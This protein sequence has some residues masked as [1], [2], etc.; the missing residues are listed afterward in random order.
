[1]FEFKNIAEAKLKYYHL[2][3]QGPASTLRC[4]V[5]G[6]CSRDGL[7]SLLLIL[8]LVIGSHP[9]TT[10]LTKLRHLYTQLKSTSK[11]EATKTQQD[12][13]INVVINSRL[14]ACK[15]E[16]GQA[17]YYVKPTLKVD[18]YFQVLALLKI[19]SLLVFIN[20][21]YSKSFQLTAPN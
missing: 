1:V 10:A 11:T 14:L 16:I 4:E 13:P 21:L 2:V 18:P 15:T 6:C 8:R 12:R 9:N 20:Q 19:M 7:P 5:L 17:L 3:I